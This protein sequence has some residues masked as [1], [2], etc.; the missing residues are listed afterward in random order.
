MH[1]K[2]IALI[3]AASVVIT[4]LAA[5]PARADSD[6]ARLLADCWPGGPFSG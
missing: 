1:R 6:T 4:G 3:L 5:V 2:F